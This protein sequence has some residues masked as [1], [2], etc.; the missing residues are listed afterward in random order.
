[1]EVFRDEAP[2]AIRLELP[3][4]RARRSIERIE[5]AVVTEEVNQ[6]V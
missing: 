1:M 4:Q 6:A 2:F 5:I 3:S